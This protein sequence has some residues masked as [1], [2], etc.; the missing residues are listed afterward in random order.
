[1]DW[2]PAALIVTILFSALT[3]FGLG[4]FVV[5]RS[6]I[7]WCCGIGFVVGVGL[8]VIGEDLGSL[9]LLVGAPIAAAVASRF[10]SRTLPSS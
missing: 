3:G 10:S 1:M 9:A 6:L 4:R 2:D 5:P 7:W 8:A